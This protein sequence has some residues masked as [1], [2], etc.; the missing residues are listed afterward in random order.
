MVTDANTKLA[1]SRAQERAKSAHGASRVTDLGGGKY[2]VLSSGGDQ[3]Y[4]VTVIERPVQELFTCSCV[5]G[6]FGKLCKHKSWVFKARTM[7]QMKAATHP[8][9]PA[10]STSARA[11][12][13]PEAY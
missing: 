2:S 11:A 13:W 5:A 12:I 7:A 9:R 6:S 10:R 3:F 8:E 1:Y 4:T